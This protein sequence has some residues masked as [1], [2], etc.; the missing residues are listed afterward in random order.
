MDEGMDLSR[1]TSG[2]VLARRFERCG[3][4]SSELLLYVVDVV[5]REYLE[6]STI[7]CWGLLPRNSRIRF[8]FC[9]WVRLLSA[10]PRPIVMTPFSNLA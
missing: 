4:L 8:D 3:F 5:L 7:T 9:L 2:D 10:C 1:W 6:I